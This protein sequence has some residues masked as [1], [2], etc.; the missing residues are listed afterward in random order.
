MMMMINDTDDEN[1][2]DCDNYD[3]YS[4]P[5]NIQNADDD[6]VEDHDGDDASEDDYEDDDA[7]EED[8]D[9]D[10]DSFLAHSVSSVTR[11]EQPAV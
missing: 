10:N 3:A 5:N 4:H 9:D 6:D 1:D 11:V 7:A 2:I 8:D